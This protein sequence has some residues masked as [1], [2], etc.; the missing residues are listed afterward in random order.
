MMTD[1][2]IRMLTKEIVVYIQV[3]KTVADKQYRYLDKQW[4]DINL[5]TLPVSRTVT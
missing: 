3:G 4:L 5:L 1:T 2:V